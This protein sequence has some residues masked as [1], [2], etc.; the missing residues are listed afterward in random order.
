LLLQ[1]SLPLDAVLCHIIPFYAYFFQSVSFIFLT[2]ALCFCC[3]PCCM[4]WL[5][6]LPW[7]N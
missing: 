3:Y 2:K 6:C 4:Q 5:F 1:K 7:F